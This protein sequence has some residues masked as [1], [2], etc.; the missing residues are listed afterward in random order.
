ML[1][2]DPASTTLGVDDQIAVFA[3]D[4]LF[5]KQV[6]FLVVDLQVGL[7]AVADDGIHHIAANAEGEHVNVV[8]LL[9]V[10]AHDDNISHMV[11]IPVAV[12]VE[13]EAGPIPWTQGQGIPEEGMAVDHI[14]VP[15]VVEVRGGMDGSVCRG[16]GA[17]V[18]GTGIAAT[19]DIGVRRRAHIATGDLTTAAHRGAADGL[20]RGGGRRTCAFASHRGR[21]GAAARGASHGAACRC[22]RAVAARATIRAAARRHA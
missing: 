17:G 8:G 20:A 13:P 9:D 7:A 5:G 4:F 15:R 19:A 3:V 22:R 14:A 10:V 16:Q 18:T 6:V 21:T 1:L 11:V 12:A 2:A